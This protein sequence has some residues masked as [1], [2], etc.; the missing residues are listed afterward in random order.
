MKFRR[1]R[2]TYSSV[3][4]LCDCLCR[5]HSVRCDDRCFALWSCVSFTSCVVDFESG[6]AF[7]CLPVCQM[8]S[9]EPSAISKTDLIGALS[10]TARTALLEFVG[11]SVYARRADVSKL[12][13]TDH[14]SMLKPF[15]RL[16]KETSSQ[17]LVSLLLGT[18]TDTTPTLTP[19][20]PH[21]TQHAQHTTN[22][23]NHF[24]PVLKN[25]RL[26]EFTRSALNLRTGGGEKEERRQNDKRR[27]TTT[28]KDTTH[29]TLHTTHNIFYFF[30]MFL[31]F[32][33][34]VFCCCRCFL[35]GW[36]E[37]KERRRRDSFGHLLG[38]LR[39]HRVRGSPRKRHDVVKVSEPF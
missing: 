23:N 19:T 12:L 24:L 37:E 21:T 28:R 27:Q 30:K 31:F 10:L 1:A 39:T 18:H 35:A 38:D 22:N 11:T 15:S 8:I 13:S 29:D 17:D 14:V 2:A 3:R 34:I 20:P 25:T 26:L 32:F 16:S 9:L 33:S 6:D 5:K 36:R 4:P 7:P